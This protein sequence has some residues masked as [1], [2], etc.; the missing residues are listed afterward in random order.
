MDRDDIARDEQVVELAALDAHRGARGVGEV[1]TPCEH[2]HAERVT[3]PRD[4][5]PDA[6]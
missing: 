5:A 6:P 3:Q 4:V 1:G 2:A